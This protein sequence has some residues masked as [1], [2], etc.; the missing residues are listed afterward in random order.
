MIAII[1][2]QRSSY[3]KG[4]QTKRSTS[5][6]DEEV[7]LSIDVLRDL[8]RS[9]QPYDCARALPYVAVLFYIQTE[10]YTFQQKLVRASATVV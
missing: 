3:T 7:H 10:T 9:I 1:D 8:P 4:T 2:S 5:G 6:E